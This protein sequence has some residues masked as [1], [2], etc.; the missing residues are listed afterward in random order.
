M[1]LF[2]RLCGYPLT[3]E[4]TISGTRRLEHRNH[5]ST[6]ANYVGLLHKKLLFHIHPD[7]FGQFPMEK[8]CNLVN[9]QELSTRI[10]DSAKPSNNAMRSLIFYIK[11]SGTDNSPRRV[12]IILSR[13]AE[14]MREIL[15]DLDTELPD[16]PAGGS[17]SSSTFDSN[18]HFRSAFNSTIDPLEVA[19]FL[20]TIA[21]R[22]DL[23]TWRQA[24]NA[25]FLGIQGILQSILGCDRIDL[26]YNWSAQNN[27]VLFSSLLSLLESIEYK[28]RMTGLDLVLTA[29]DFCRP[30]DAVE[31]HVLLNPGHVPNQWKDALNAVT[32]SVLQEAHTARQLIE[33]MTAEMSVV[34]GSLVR[35]ALYEASKEKLGSKHIFVAVK[36]GHT[37]SK[38]WFM[39]FLRSWE[40][41]TP[42]LNPRGS[43][44]IAL[45]HSIQ[46]GDTNSNRYHSPDIAS[47]SIAST[48]SSGSAL[49]TSLCWLAQLPLCI[50][51]VV[52]EGHGSK[53]L[54]TGA[55]RIDCRASRDKVETLLHSQALDSVKK[56]AENKQTL[57]KIEQ[58]RANI[59]EQLDIAGLDAGVGVGNEKLAE[60]LSRVDAYLRAQ[61]QGNRGVLGSLRGMRIKVGRYLGIG[62]DG[63]V[64]LPF[65]ITFPDN[66]H[67]QQQ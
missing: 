59:V 65:N 46:R 40:D 52:E 21:D 19:R 43:S 11:P 62:D 55:F 58:L 51:V 30:V 28:T 48:S 13:L 15:E 37:C 4:S 67:P 23:M 39:H 44:V 26:R 33:T 7:F 38:R 6:F 31:G 64:S 5:S 35:E 60:F 34:L 66:L 41:T 22:R 9:M 49:A 45:E 3:R 42:L 56:T 54:E 25:S 63:S 61:R 29:D 10:A 36:R 32:P 12:K 27:A 47:P 17:S 24:R 2:R 8:N 20:D 18:A 50:Q 53:L 57:L 16:A 14:S 1:K